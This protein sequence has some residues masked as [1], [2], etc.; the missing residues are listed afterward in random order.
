M[1]PVVKMV[2]VRTIISLVACKGWTSWQLNMKN[3]FLDGKLD[4]EVLMDQP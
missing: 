2:I 4:G 3:V 1:S